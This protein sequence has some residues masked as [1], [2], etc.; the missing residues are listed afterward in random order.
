MRIGLGQGNDRFQELYLALHDKMLRVAYRM[1]GTVETAE[2]LVQDAFLLALFQEEALLRHPVPEGWLMRTL[3]NLTLNERRRLKR[4]PETPLESLRHIA[5]GSPAGSLEDM[6]PTGLSPQD[7]EILIWRFQ[8][9]RDYDEIAARLGI[10]QTGCR[11]RVSR[12]VKRCR[13]LLE[14]T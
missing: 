1:T 8:E 9:N 11:S 2:D 5:G 12:A 6:L 3:Q 7:R 14:R 13:E 10:S 4:H